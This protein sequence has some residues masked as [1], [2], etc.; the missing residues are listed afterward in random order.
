MPPS[1]PKTNAFLFSL[2]RNF[3]ATETRNNS[4]PGLSP[5]STG[6][7]HVCD[8]AGLVRTVA[9]VAQYGSRRAPGLESVSPEFK[10]CST[11]Y[12]LC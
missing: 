4:G 9:C 3:L 6:C 8:S 1:S 11:T 5:Y 12:C 10:S 7:P 2:A